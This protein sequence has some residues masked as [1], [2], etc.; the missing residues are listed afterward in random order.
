MSHKP[1]IALCVIL[2]IFI[3][4][5]YLNAWTA[6]VA[7]NPPTGDVSAPINT[8][9]AYQVKGG[10]LGVVSVRAGLFCRADNSKCATLDELLADNAGGGAGF[11]LT[12]VETFF[13]DKRVQD[14]IKTY[15]PRPWMNDSEN[16]TYRVL[17]GVYS[18]DYV[19]LRF[20]ADDETANRIC[21]LLSAGTKQEMDSSPTYAALRTFDNNPQPDKTDMSASYVGVGMFNYDGNAWNYRIYRSASEYGESW[22]VNQ[23]GSHSNGAYLTPEPEFESLYE[24]SCG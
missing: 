6:P 24:L 10:D 17:E 15:V 14:D 18:G 22:P 3:V 13:A 23:N 7:G 20:A 8:G 16:W 5:D 21:E 12:D 4:G 1:L 11:P 9:S 19:S 2:T